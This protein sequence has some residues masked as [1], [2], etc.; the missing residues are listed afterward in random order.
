[1]LETVVR[2]AL[3]QNL[4]LQAALARVAQARA[5]AQGAGAQLLPTVDAVGSVAK[6][7]QSLN[8]PLG[9]IART[10]P[11][12]SRTQEAFR[13]GG[14]ASWEI[15]LS[16]GLRRDRDAAIAEDQAPQADQTGTRLTLS[17]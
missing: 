2:R 9:A 7:Q 1:M 14:S 3:D 17:A 4:S 8:S 13:V 5:V 6:Q 11:N 15:D 16:G 12:Y 10:F